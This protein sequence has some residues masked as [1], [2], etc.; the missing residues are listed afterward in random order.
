MLVI[1]A[2]IVLLSMRDALGIC[3]AAF[4]AMPSLA[5]ILHATGF[6]EASHNVLYLFAR[7]LFAPLL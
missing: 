6:N 3:F 1:L 7:I 2:R 5:L 4:A